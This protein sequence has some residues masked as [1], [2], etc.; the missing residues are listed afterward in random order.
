MKGSKVGLA[1]SCW[2]VELL[3][4]PLDNIHSKSQQ[5][6]KRLTFSIIEEDNAWELEYFLYLWKC[7]SQFIQQSRLAN[8]RKAHKTNSCISTFSNI[9]TFASTST[10]LSCRGKELPPQFCKFSLAPI[11]EKRLKKRSW[12]C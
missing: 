4:A 9:K 7:P 10:S 8:R 5:R 2:K 3:W 6:N 1:F 12:K 11:V